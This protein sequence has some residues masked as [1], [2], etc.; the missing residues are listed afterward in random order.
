MR[1]NK[2]TAETQKHRGKLG[3]TSSVIANFFLALAFYFNNSVALWFCGLCFFASTS[4]A[5]QKI[6]V[7]IPEKTYQSQIFAE[8]LGNSLTKD[9]KVLDDSLS[10]A[11]FRSASYE[12]PFNL[13][14]EESKNIGAAI[15]CDYFLLIKAENQRRYSFEKKEYY[16]SYA[17]VY[18]VSSRTGRLV[19]W[20]LAGSE[21]ETTEKAEKKLFASINNLSA[22]ISDQL[23]TT[24]TDELNEKAA[25]KLEK[26]PAENS[27]EAKNFR[28]PLPYRRIKPPYTRLANLYTVEATIDIEIDVDENGKIRRTEITR[29]AGFGLDESVDKTIRQMNWKPADR[30]GKSLPM[31]VLLRYN[32]K[33][34]Q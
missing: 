23:K 9:F 11:A 13:S 7:L 25:Q 10:A 4:F 6:A 22:E 33:K 27:L 28:P 16:E 24:T 18:A 30:D 29:W 20:K 15:G 12:K 5:Q 32:F 34:I 19:F 2:F 17:V 14:L 1:M 31:R 8:K 3:K 21:A 26:L